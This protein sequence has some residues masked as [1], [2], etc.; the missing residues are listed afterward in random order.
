MWTS[1]NIFQARSMTIFLDE[2]DCKVLEEFPDDK[3][4]LLLKHYEEIK[5]MHEEIKKK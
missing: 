3:R 4:K 5:V 2:I 1:I